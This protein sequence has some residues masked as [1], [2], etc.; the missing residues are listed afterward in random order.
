VLRSLRPLPSSR[1]YSS[2]AS[3]SASSPPPRLSLHDALPICPGFTV[4]YLQRGVTHLAGLLTED[5]SQEPLFGREFGFP[6]R[7]HL[8]H[9]DVAGGHFRT[10]A[11]DAPL[12]EVPEDPVGDV[13]DVAGDLSRPELGV[14]GADLVL[15]AA[16]R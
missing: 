2:S 4:G 9:E 3:P 7:G 16:G 14:P 5:R 15:H 6:L 11:H 8:P 1:P 12:V 13:G 10:D